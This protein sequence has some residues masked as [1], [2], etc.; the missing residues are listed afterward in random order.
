MNLSL[1]KKRAEEQKITL[2]RLSSDIGMSYQN[3]NRCIKENKISANDLE[4]ISQFL[5][6]P[7]SYFFGSDSETKKI[8]GDNNFVGQ[9]TSTQIYSGSKNSNNTSA[10]DEL[11]KA[12]DIIIKKL[13]EENAECKRVKD[14]YSMVVDSLFLNISNLYVDIVEQDGKIKPLL[15]KHKTTNN[16]LAQLNTFKVV[17]GVNV[18]LNEKFYE[19]FESPY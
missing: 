7:I 4:R 18:E 16:L 11:L 12:K 19:Y 8:I 2:K 13:E 15:S 17:S 1:I 6:V 9:G 10:D 3:L 14:F 5:D